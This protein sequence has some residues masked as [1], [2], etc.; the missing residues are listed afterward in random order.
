MLPLHRIHGYMRIGS[1]FGGFASL[2]SPTPPWTATEAS[3]HSAFDMPEHS[4]AGTPINTSKTKQ[5]IKGAG[6]VR[7]SPALTATPPRPRVPSPLQRPLPPRVLCIGCPPA[8]ARW[9]WTGPCWWQVLSVSSHMAEA[10]LSPV[11]LPPPRPFRPG[12]LVQGLAIDPK[13]RIPMQLAPEPDPWF[14]PRTQVT[15][16]G[17]VRRALV[18]EAFGEQVGARRAALPSPWSA[19]RSS[20]VGPATA[21]G[22]GGGGGRGGGG[23]GGG[24]H[25]GGC[26]GGWERRR[27]RTA[28]AGADV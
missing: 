17:N 27:V 8:W 24:G 25:G 3:V 4:H 28:R 14:E 13:R 23:G 26:G 19:Y 2:R 18:A 15:T 7:H 9:R 11:P 16:L 5:V 1:E 20:D 6:K 22:W 21:A 10:V 12:T